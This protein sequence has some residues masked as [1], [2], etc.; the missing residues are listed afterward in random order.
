MSIKLSLQG[1]T[2]NVEIRAR[3]P[4]LVCS[5]DDREVTV[6]EAQNLSGECSCITIGGQ[7][8]QAWRAPDGDSVW[9]HIGGRVFIVDVSN[10]LDS[11]NPSAQATN[12]ICADMP[13]MV[14][15]LHTEIGATVASG[16]AIVTIESMKMQIVL[17]APRAGV[18]DQIHQ[19]P[20]VAFDKGAMLVS[21]K[22][23]ID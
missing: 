6:A 1:Q 14:V 8:Y 15:E 10:P 21:L 12:E 18:I 19:Q 9:V 2:S 13:G 7:H 3:N 22:P 20:N 11:A 23:A 17:H 4:S 5:V 16:D